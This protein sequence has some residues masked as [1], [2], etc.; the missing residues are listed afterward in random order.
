MSFYRILFAFVAVLTTLGVNARQMCIG[1]LK[2]DDNFSQSG[3]AKNDTIGAAVFV[4]T[5]ELK[6]MIGAELTSVSFYKHENAALKYLKVFVA[7]ELGT[8]VISEKVVDVATIANGWNEVVLDMPILLTGDSLYLGYYLLSQTS[9][10]QAVINTSTVKSF[11]KRG[12]T[13]QWTSAKGVAIY[14]T[15]KGDNLPA[16]DVV[17]SYGMDVEVV[18][19]EINKPFDVVFVVENIAA[20]T[21][22][23]IEMECAL[24]GESVEKRVI[25]VKIPYLTKDS[26]VF[27]NI[28]I[29]ELGSRELNFTVTKLNSEADLTPENNSC[30]VDVNV[31]ERIVERKV[32]LEVFSTENCTNCPKGHEKIEHAIVGRQDKV[33]EVGHHVGFYT[34]QWTVPADTIYMN[35]Y[36]A[37][38]ITTFAPAG[39]LDRT[40]FSKAD[41]HYNSYQGGDSCVVFSL[42]GNETNL[43]KMIDVQ[44]AKPAYA[45]IDLEVDFNEN[46][47]MLTINTSGKSV[48]ELGGDPR[49]T[50]YVTEDNLAT[51]KQAGWNSDRKGLYYQ[52]NVNRYIATGVW[53]DSIALNEGF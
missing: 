46:D 5:E 43:G 36:Y 44:L 26:I 53:G 37:A 38:I 1:N 51:T 30:T 41:G 27:E 50:I 49:L 7:S 19:V 17:L 28:I 52:H 21:I 20:D 10:S 15:V 48:A 2:F 24:G 25:D 33:I 34:D 16:H 32:L 47:S 18:D 12:S 29:D 40:L 39:V 4:S 23:T 22:R 31:V 11:M 35:F 42:D 14:G 9:L 6:N 45:W 13:A 3:L 8:S